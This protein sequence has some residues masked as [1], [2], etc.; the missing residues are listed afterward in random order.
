M[1][2]A[3]FKTQNLKF[4][5]AACLALFALTGSAYSEQ[6]KI[7]KIG[8]V[9][10]NAAS[11]PGP[12]VEAFRQGLR[13][14]GYIEGKNIV[15]EYRWSAGKDEEIPK[16]VKEL[17]ELK[18]DVLVLPVPA[19]IRAGK[20]LTKTTPIVMIGSEDPVAMGLAD[21]LAHPGGNLTGFS[22]LQREL[23]GKRLELMKEAVAPL[24]RV[25]VLFDH[26]SQ[27]GTIGLTKYQA[28]APSLKIA[29]ET[30][31]VDGPRP[32]F[33]R[34][35]KSAANSRLNGL[36]T[37][38]STTLF[39]RQKEV[40][41]FALKHR[42]PSMFEGSTWV[43]SG[44]LMSYSTN[45]REVFRRAAVYIDKILRGAN[46]GNLPIEQPK[47]FELVVNLKT[48]KQIGVT[49]SQSVLYRADKVIK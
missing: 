13:D 16:L 9:S 42:L 30:L 25:G 33:E 34:A 19:A 10:T 40:A 14:K 27:T 49:I 20:E 46:P 18:V 5:F 26:D 8:Y 29:L 39:R 28:A 6:A 23:S 11:S 43:E 32:D 4:A 3:K 15:V 22:R 2:N 35:F 31:E 38:T 7:P 24:Q 47:K 21:S 37:I 44:G 1:M 12:L 45:D 17:L 41:A 48:A 36:I